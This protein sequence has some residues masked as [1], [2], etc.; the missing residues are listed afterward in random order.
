MVKK[1]SWKIRESDTAEDMTCL[2]DSPANWSV[3]QIICY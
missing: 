1:D 3:D 2:V